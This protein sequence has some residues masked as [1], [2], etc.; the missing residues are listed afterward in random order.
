MVAVS[1]FGLQT[2]DAD[3]VSVGD[4]VMGGRSTG[5]VEPLDAVTSVFQGE[6]SLDNGGGFASVKCD[7]PTLDLSRFEGLML[8]ARG[9]GKR[10]K[11][12]LRMTWDRNA[13]V[14]Q[15]AFA[16]EADVW[17]HIVLPF[18]GFVASFRG[19]TLPDAP[20][21]DPA[22]VASLSLFISGKQAGPFA[23]A[24]HGIEAY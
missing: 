14:Y 13:P 1:R 7:I 3:W 2:G 15:Q 17:D 21:L 23:L 5:A 16:T 24:L 9:D 22:H 20:A 19:R 6:V 4:P 11:L 8:E 18:S 12:G 10:Y